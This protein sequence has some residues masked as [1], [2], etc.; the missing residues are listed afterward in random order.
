[1]MMS[2]CDSIVGF[3]EAVELSM[4]D[5]CKI[6]TPTE[7]LENDG[8]VIKSYAQSTSTPCRWTAVSS[9]ESSRDT[10]I[11]VT[12]VWKIVLPL[13]TQVTYESRVLLTHKLGVELNDPIEAQ[14]DGDPQVIIGALQCNL[15]AIKT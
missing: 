2:E 9:S 4:R 1:M 3:T 7:T 14:V 6:L 8:E 10:Y 11:L 12:G 5:R 13:G 15:K